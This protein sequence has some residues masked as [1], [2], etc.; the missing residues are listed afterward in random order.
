VL[1][2]VSV[3]A[4]VPQ[5]ASLGIDRALLAVEEANARVIELT[6]R[7]ASIEREICK[8][9][10]ELHDRNPHRRNALEQGR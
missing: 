10:Q 3:G 8:A 5:F 4:G 2:E 1:Q 7:L 9:K 6:Q